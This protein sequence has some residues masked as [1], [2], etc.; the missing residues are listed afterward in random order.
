MPATQPPGYRW[1]GFAALALASALAL[2]GWWLAGRPVALPDVPGGKFQ[3][4]SYAP[5]RGHETPFDP[6]FVVP[7]ARIEADLKALSRE[8]QCVRIY[9]TDQ[10]LD[11]TVPI[12]QRLGLKVI[13]GAW[14]G[15]DPANNAMQVSTAIAF[16]NAYPDTVKALVVGNEVLLRGEMP[17]DQLADLIHRVRAETRAVVTYADVWEFWLSYPAVTKAVDLMIIHILPY[18]EDD[19]VG[20]DGAMRHAQ[21]IMTRVKSAF[22]DKTVMI[23]ETGWP[24]AGRMREGARPGRVEQT[25]YMREFAGLAQREGW[26][27]NL[28][29]A[30]DQPW[31]RALEGTVG[32]AW[33]LYAGDRT[34]KVT[35]TGPVSD[36]PDWRLQG[37]IALMLGAAPVL[38]LLGAGVRLSPARW[39]AVAGTAEIVAAAAVR[40]LWYAGITS[41]TIVEWAASLG[42]VALT[43]A[44]GWLFVAWLAGIAEASAGGSFRQTLA[45]LRRP[46]RAAPNRPTLAGA[47]ALITVLWIAWTLLT[48]VFDPRYRDFP[49]SGFLVPALVFALFAWLKREPPM[50][51][52][53]RREEAALA[54]L[55]L[56]GGLVLALKETLLNTQALAFVAVAWLAAVAP[57]IAWRRARAAATTSRLPAERRPA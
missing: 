23:G 31:K 2:G 35:A 10:G 20:I 18:W 57:V 14:I 19:P 52:E 47:L 30:F 26:A 25:R 13:L 49:T 6:A 40:H 8:V 12:A 36:M 32:G 22:P 41:R 3:C 34:A 33:G 54:V 24:S 27:Y 28:V 15:R 53:N 17:P 38:F 21:E 56:A 5:Y 44:V 16:A 7:P 1:L 9:A 45:W 48:L 43:L 55:L 11:M 29:E 37:L 42:R 51:G 46:R 4:V 50:P 39:L